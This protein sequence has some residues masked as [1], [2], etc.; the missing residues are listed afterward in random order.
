[1]RHP[2][3]T[4]P[5]DGKPIILEDAVAGTYELVEWSDRECAWVANNGKASNI[6]P[7][8]W[9]AVQRSDHVA[10][11]SEFD[12]PLHAGAM[13]R[14]SMDRAEA[15][16]LVPPLAPVDLIPGPTK[17]SASVS[18]PRF[19]EQVPTLKARLSESRRRFAICCGLAM[20][21][22]SLCSMFFRADVA[23]YLTERADQHDD[24]RVGNGSRDALPLHPVRSEISMTDTTLLQ[25][26]AQGDTLAAPVTV[27]KAAESA[28]GSKSV[29]RADALESE[30]ST[31]RQE[32]SSNSMQYRQA[33]AEA[34]ERETQQKRTAETATTELR[35]SL[36]QAREKIL[37]L[38]K[39]LA[40]AGQPVNQ[41]AL[42]ER[43]ARRIP[44]RQPKERKRQGF[45][46]ENRSLR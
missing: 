28:Q 21:A 12:G 40:L 9:H 7:G 17:Q 32:L 24:V 1:M 44:Q 30:L 42:P 5:K 38:E 20:V 4:A 2:M 16:P 37:T 41:A 27:G 35:Q 29:G 31:L 10:L 22:G 39:E 18:I 15:P 8:Y 43:Q 25:A 19:Q 23:A 33:L 26:E 3:E 36:Q 34:L 6:T 45:F 46:G 13:F 14:K 11:E